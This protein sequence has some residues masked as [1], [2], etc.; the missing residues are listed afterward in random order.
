MHLLLGLL[1]ADPES[2]VLF[3]LFFDLGVAAVVALSSTA[4]ASISLTTGGSSVM[5]VDTL[6]GVAAPDFMMG[7]AAPLLAGLLCRFHKLVTDLF[8][9]LSSC[10]GLRGVVLVLENVPGGRYSVSHDSDLVSLTK[11]YS[12]AASSSADSDLSAQCESFVHTI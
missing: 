11:A 1:G 2:L 9:A 8:M 6:T 5:G 4:G 3:D 12:A 7:E 10:A